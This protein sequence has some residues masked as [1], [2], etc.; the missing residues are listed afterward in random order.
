MT[1]ANRSLMKTLVAAILVASCST[2]KGA[3]H[4]ATLAPYLN[5][6][7]FVLAY[8]DVASAK[9]AD[10]QSLLRPLPDSSDD[11]F[12]N[13]LA[14]RIGENVIKSLH[15]VGIESVY[16]VLG[17]GDVFPDRG[18]LFILSLK[19]DAD[20][21][22]VEDVLDEL[23]P[24]MSNGLDGRT[25]LIAK[26][27]G[28]STFLVGTA[29]TVS[30]YESLAATE[31]DDLA[32]PLAKL[33]DDGAALAIVFSPGNDFRRVVRELWPAMPVP[34]EELRG[35]LADRWLRLEFAAK[36]QPQLSAEL[37]MQASDAK[38]A[39]LFVQ[40]LEALPEAVENITEI[41]KRRQELKR[42]L[43]TLIETVPPR[44]DGARV[45]MTLPTNEAQLA[46][47][48]Q[49]T[50]EATDA[51]LE[52]TRRQQRVQQF[53]QMALAMQTYADAKKHL[54]PPAITDQN[55]RRLLSWRVAILPYLEQN[56]LYK[57][58]HLDEPWDS[59]HNRT[60]IDKM[61]EIYADPNPQIRSLAGKSKTTYVV[62]AGPG[63]VFDTKDGITFRDIP[64]G[65][66][67]TIILVEVP[68]ER[69]VVWTK[70]EDWDVD[71][72]SPPQGIERTDRDYFT[73]GWCD[74]RASVIPFDVDRNKLRAVLTRA[75]GEVVD[76][77]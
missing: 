13:V 1:P 47:L 19:P 27:H 15:S 9:S 76:W 38:S 24:F 55:G 75:G 51:A 67:N 58:F 36:T 8:L 28:P 44:V 49:L 41:G 68:P 7:T 59:P 73:A 53:K 2:A 63:T 69:A 52:S 42:V 70:P 4:A 5:D 35:E 61:P 40:L 64:D 3:N 37:V 31:R 21:Q 30:K 62:P 60:L 43:S 12:A 45:V 25:K 66:S 6:E 23:T 50:G 16:A 71:L 56:N 11:S 29:S 10:W 17:L 33:A 32:D 26:R 57:Q 18:Q 48:R 20:A 46:K 22:A 14:K 65:T 74:G 39:A 77:P 72:A 54:P 34:L